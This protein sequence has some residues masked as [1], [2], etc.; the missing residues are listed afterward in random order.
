M[1]DDIRLSIFH[2]LS[3]TGLGRLFQDATGFT[4]QLKKL[5]ASGG[6]TLTDDIAN[7][8]IEVGLTLPSHVVTNAKLAQMTAH[9]YKGNNTGS[10]TDPS[11][12]SAANVTADLSV[13]GGDGGSGGVKGLVPAQAAGDAAAG[14]FLK[15]D[16]SWAVPPSGGITQLTSDVTA[17]PG[18]G[19]QGATIANDAVTYAKMQNVSAAS[20]LVGRGSASGSGNPEEITLGAGLVMT[21]TSLD[22]SGPILV[23]LKNIT[24][25]E[26]R[27]MDTSA[28]IVV[29]AG[30]AAGFFHLP[31]MYAVAVNVTSGFSANPGMTLRW[32]TGATATGTG[33]QTLTVN[34]IAKRYIR[35]IVPGG[36]NSSLANIESS[37]LE[38]FNSVTCTGGATNG[39]F[40]VYV[41]YMVIAI[42]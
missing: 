34:A 42:P 7:N 5:L 28:P 33:A 18:S 1:A 41:W 30:P 21:G 23:A 9:T 39:G 14:K 32:T 25:A 3:L 38:V 37:A 4:F 26:Y 27:A 12:V 19:S 8:A 11:D 10:T 31:L 20:R 22:V 16:A 24:D 40:N 29:L 15:A 17:G 35:S 36:Q 6:I 2:P 13:M